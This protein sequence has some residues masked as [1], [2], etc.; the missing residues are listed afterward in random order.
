M[1]YFGRNASELI[2]KKL[3][4]IDM[5]GTIYKEERLFDGAVELLKTIESFGGKYVF[6]TNNSS[7]SVADYITKLK[8]H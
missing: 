2:A 7:K 3:W 6:I 5:D 8:H 4:L 1:D